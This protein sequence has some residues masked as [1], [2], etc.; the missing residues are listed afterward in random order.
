M[1]AHYREDEIQAWIDLYQQD[2]M[3]TRDVAMIYSVPQSTVSAAFRKRG[4][5]AKNER[6][7]ITVKKLRP[8]YE[9]AKHLYSTGMEAKAIGLQLGINRKTIYNWIKRPDWNPAPPTVV[10]NIWCACGANFT[11]IDLY[12]IH[13]KEAHQ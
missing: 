1:M 6:L 4:I 3:T 7:H 5:V 9:Q 8:L 2:T 12:K 13:K 11:T 10:A